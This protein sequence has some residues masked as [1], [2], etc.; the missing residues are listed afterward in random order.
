M[1]SAYGDRRCLN[2]E[3][4]A[5]AVHTTRTR[6]TA[7]TLLACMLLTGCAMGPRPIQYLWQS[8]EELAYYVD[9]ASSIE[10]P[11]ESEPRPIAEDLLTAPRSIY[12]LD[13]VK[14]REVTLSECILMA[15]DSEVIID[16]TSL[17]N[18]G[19]PVLSRPANAPSIYDI[20][21]QESGFLFGN[22]GIEAS[23]ADYD[24]TLTGTGSWG[25]SEVP[26]NLANSGLPQGSVLTTETMNAS[27][28]L[29]KP[30][31]TGG[32][33][34]VQMDTI[35]DGNNRPS[36]PGPGSV[37]L[38]PSSYNGFLRAEFR[39]P[40]LAGSGVEF[41][42][43]AGPVNQN[44]RGVSGVSQG[45][46]ISRINRD[47]SH[48]Q[49]EQSTSTMVRD[50]ERRYWDLRLKLEL[51]QSERKAFHDLLELKGRLQGRQVGGP[52]VVEADSRLLEADARI[53]GSLA[54][55]LES[56]AR[57]RRL[58]HL[59]INDG[60]FLTPADM[61]TSA[62]LL[63]EWSS[64]L[65]EAFSNRVEIRRQKWEIKSLE[66]Q[67]KAAKN[68]TRPS[69]DMVARYDRNALGDRF[70]GGGNTYGRNLFTSQTD[71]WTMG[72]RASMPVGLRA[73]RTQVRNYELRLQKAR[74]MIAQQ[75]REVA[76]ELS[77]M[78][79]N[80][81]RWYSLAESQKRRVAKSRD[82]QEVIASRLER[83]KNESQYQQLLHQQLQAKAAIRDAEQGYMR[84][85]TEY[86]Q[87]LTEFAFRKGTLLTD[88]SIYLAEGP[89]H[90]AAYHGALRRAERRTHSKDAHRLQSKPIEFV[91]GSARSAWESQG[92]PG[93][94][95]TPGA[96]E[97]WSESG[98]VQLPDGNVNP[99]EPEPLP[100]TNPPTDNKAQRE[101]SLETAGHL[102]LKPVSLPGNE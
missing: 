41:N 45:V 5:S 4:G 81:Q 80:M 91:G 38:F 13:K 7:I 90:P 62:E 40:L 15:L 100:M 61:P 53:R 21:L 78:M 50:V 49:F 92:V 75:E 46:L 33:A 10:Y 31:M 29:E 84:A 55:V 48:T 66:L 16:D 44:L 79:F 83:E 2:G 58:C 64:V 14:H 72:F 60:T 93:R 97:E 74:A 82:H 69:L 87:A 12:S 85:I 18:P 95:S 99:P 35:Y 76:Y 23:L 6:L 77:D 101:D 65:Q 88:N 36:G 47:I 22:R 68:L 89:W 25:R 102:E 32:S 86:N 26:Q 43:I 70:L 39:Q 1:G 9:K 59:P 28:A 17:G 51:Y 30:F 73:A 19:N 57:L 63:P 3:L 8:E 98:R 27:V 52:A 67:L 94:P 56:E 37:Q 34:L 96:M 11:V 71:G 24:P 20:A 42:Q 54:D